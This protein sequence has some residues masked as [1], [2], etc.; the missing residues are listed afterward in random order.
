MDK[1]TIIKTAVQLEKDGRAFYLGV[2]GRTASPA[3]KQVFES[4][5]KDEENHIHW[6][7]ENLGV[8]ESAREL[9]QE[10]YARVKHIFAEIPEAKRRQAL[11]SPNDIQPLR[12]AI[13]MEIKSARA[14]AD[15]AAELADPTLKGILV[16]LAEVEQFHQEL[17]ENT[18]LYMENP[19][20]F[21]QREEGWM[22][23]G[24]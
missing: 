22:F 23:D 12:Q 15:W 11:A 17:L 20:E 7:Q 16:K 3:V 1:A 13:E 10:T 6:I 5:A 24:A 4:L 14:Y 9:N 21:F 8:A 18:I 2:A 19:A